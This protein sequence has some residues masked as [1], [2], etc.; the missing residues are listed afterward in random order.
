M[1]QQGKHGEDGYLIRE[2][3]IV[4]QIIKSLDTHNQFAGPGGWYETTLRKF[5]ASE[6]SSK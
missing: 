3:E 4:E 2:T 6:K 5:L 1:W